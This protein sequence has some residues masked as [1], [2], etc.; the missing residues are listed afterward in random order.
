MAPASAFVSASLLGSDA[1]GR[2]GEF[3]VNGGGRHAEMGGRA[4]DEGGK[5][6]SARD[7]PW[8]HVRLSLDVGRPVRRPART[9]PSRL[10]SPG[11]RADSR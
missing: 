9:R 4:E 1:V 7:G 2:Y 8:F 5:E 10:N 6:R 3:D 11:T